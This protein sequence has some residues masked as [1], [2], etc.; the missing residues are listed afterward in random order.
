M[1][2]VVLQT[3]L[4]ASSVAAQSCILE[5]SHLSDSIVAQS[6]ET[7]ALDVAVSIVPQENTS[8]RKT[9]P[10]NEAGPKGPYR[11]KDDKNLRRIGY[12][13]NRIPALTQTLSLYGLIASIEQLCG[14]GYWPIVAGG[15]FLAGIGAVRT[16]HAMHEKRFNRILGDIQSGRRE[17]LNVHESRFHKELPTLKDVIKEDV[18]FEHSV[19]ELE[20]ALKEER[21]FLE[22]IGEDVDTFSLENALSD[23]K[24]AKNHPEVIPDIGTRGQYRLI[25]HLILL[26]HQPPLYVYAHEMMHALHFRALAQRLTH[27]QLAYILKRT[28]PDTMNSL[29]FH[30][31]KEM[32][33]EHLN[34][35]DQARR[36]ETEMNDLP[37][38]TRR[39]AILL[40][41]QIAGPRGER[42]IE[43]IASRFDSLFG[44]PMIILKHFLT[45][46][47][48]RVGRPTIWLAGLDK[49]IS[50]FHG[51]LGYG[52]RHA[53]NQATQQ[54]LFGSLIP[55]LG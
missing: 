3:S 13:R 55:E 27:A 22:W 54:D 1:G 51:G 39:F 31:P 4:W 37:M 11:N 47:E 9:P 43:A 28:T 18:D 35:L 15:L 8:F 5:A 33:V 24:I 29:N 25:S 46:F 45:R 7:D 16:L 42:A 30:Y 12:W 40:L 17:P 34:R 20:T 36:G 19:I 50:I 48:R 10:P 41:R 49:K 26:G 6:D 38:A 52:N 32:I 44:G 23:L 53:Y 14:F 2:S 21:H